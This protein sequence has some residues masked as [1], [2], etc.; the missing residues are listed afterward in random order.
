MVKLGF[1]DKIGDLFI[2]N[3]MPN[4][5]VK[6]MKSLV[7]PRD[8]FENGCIQEDTS[9]EL[10]V[11]HIHHYKNL[12]SSYDISFEE[13]LI[14]DLNEPYYYVIAPY[15]SQRGFIGLSQDGTLKQIVSK[16]TSLMSER[17]K[18]DVRDK[19]CKVLLDGL[20]EGHPFSNEWTDQ[21]HKILDKEKLP[22]DSIYYLT[23]NNKFEMDYKKYYGDE[24]LINLVPI[25]YFELNLYDTYS[26]YFSIEKPNESVITRK[27][28][29]MS[30]NRAERQ[31]RTDLINF[32]KKKNYVDKGFVSYW[33][34]KLYLD[35]NFVDNDHL[36]STSD[37]L[38]EDISGV[39]YYENSYFNFVTET[40]FYEDSLFISEKVFKPIL[41]KQP[42]IVYSSPFTL[43][44][45]HRL[46][47]KTFSEVI[48]ESYDSEI[49][50][51]KRRKMIEQEITKL[52]N[53]TIEEIH[54]IYWSIKHIFDHNFKHFT[55]LIERGLDE[56]IYRI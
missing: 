3:G 56:S 11:T 12:L 34:Q 31:H 13:A 49:D 17:V 10:P 48:D 29:Y 18:S 44:Q 4:E 20:T 1:Q 5:V 26:K 24:S 33:P 41:F 39:Q 32:L 52:C 55:K 51:S 21:L 7:E 14:D 19:R 25:N 54:E 37:D 50:N 2:P 9:L 46:G 23:C 28:H 40:F 45:L 22:R 16:F 53:M 47:Y 6:R 36:I 30:L 35:T 42:F 38:M 43:K 8:V 27:K 15:G